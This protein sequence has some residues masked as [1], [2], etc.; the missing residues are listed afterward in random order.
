MPHLM[1]RQEL[2]DGNDS[3]NLDHQDDLDE[4]AESSN[5]KNLE[6]EGNHFLLASQ[7]SLLQSKQPRKESHQALLQ[8]KICVCAHKGSNGYLAE[9]H[10]PPSPVL[11]RVSA[12][13]V[14][15]CSK[16]SHV[17]PSKNCPSTP[18]SHYTI[19]H[20]L[21]MYFGSYDFICKKCGQIYPPGYLC[22]HIAYKHL[23]NVNITITGKL[24]KVMS[25]SPIFS[26]HMVFQR[27]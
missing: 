26:P 25:S 24:R 7:P 4:N 21:W 3:K 6:N 1:H 19:L 20:K 27:I 15:H 22:C 11:P 14:L 9:M 2:L 18:V 16:T 12:G 8:K 13:S 5:Y 23:D 17:N 10:A